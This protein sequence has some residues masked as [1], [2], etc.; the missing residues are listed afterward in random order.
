MREIAKNHQHIFMEMI[1]SRI[2]KFFFTLTALQN[3]LLADVEYFIYQNAD[4]KKQDIMG[5]TAL[6][7]GKSRFSCLFLLNLNKK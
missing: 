5:N 2:K 4:I 6:I 7:F 1:S 3:N